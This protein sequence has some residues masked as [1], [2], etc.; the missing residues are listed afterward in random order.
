MRVRL[1][2][3]NDCVYFLDRGGAVVCFVI[4][5]ECIVDNYTEGKMYLEE[6]LLIFEYGYSSRY[7]MHYETV[8]FFK[9][10]PG[11]LCRN[12][13]T[14]VLTVVPKSSLTK[15]FTVIAKVRHEPLVL[16][17]KPKQNEHEVLPGDVLDREV[18]IFDDFYDMST[19]IIADAYAEPGVAVSNNTYRQIAYSLSALGDRIQGQL[20]II[21]AR[22]ARM[23]PDFTD[24]FQEA[25]QDEMQIVRNTLQKT[26]TYPD[27]TEGS[28]ASTVVPDD[29][30][31]DKIADRIGSYGFTHY[32][33]T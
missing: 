3:D 5:K 16:N 25:L 14:S 4:H 22:I 9:G 33:T 7:C 23:H 1:C 11:V 24:L 18:A 6:G 27:E 29:H 30:E 19:S 8:F 2:I 28:Q 20:P 15:Q 21:Y 12:N 32:D 10:K 17:P 13:E 31:V 26:E